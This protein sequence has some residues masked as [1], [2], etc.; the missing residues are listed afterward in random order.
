MTIR[1]R[2]MFDD[3]A[4]EMHL[5]ERPRWTMLRL[6]NISMKAR[7]CYLVC[8]LADLLGW[9][10]GWLAGLCAGWLAGW[11]VDWLA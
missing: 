1:R 8:E 4:L 2:S 10:V 6:E 7:G 9:L 11:L 5:G 3:D